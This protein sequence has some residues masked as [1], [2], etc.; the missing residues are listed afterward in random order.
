MLALLS[1]S[2]FE[3]HASLPRSQIS[4]IL[5]RSNVLSEQKVQVSFPRAT[6]DY[7]IVPRSYADEA[8]NQ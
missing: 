3:L 6:G 4:S 8:D 7:S 5:P 2:V 1:I